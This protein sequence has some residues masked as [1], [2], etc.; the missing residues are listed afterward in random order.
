MHKTKYA[1]TGPFRAKLIKQVRRPEPACP[2]GPM[3]V[4]PALHIWRRKSA[5]L[6]LTPQTCRAG[7][8]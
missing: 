2:L 6:L 5:I 1:S 3:M 4:T 8:L 7:H